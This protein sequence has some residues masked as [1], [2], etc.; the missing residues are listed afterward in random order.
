MG[1]RL[2]LNAPGD[3]NIRGLKQ[4]KASGF[5]QPIRGQCKEHPMVTTLQRKYRWRF[6]LIEIVWKHAKYS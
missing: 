1:V 6:H 5:L 3:W 4:I 2:N